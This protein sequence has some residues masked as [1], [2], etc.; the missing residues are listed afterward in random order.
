M[1][2]H[3]G[4]SRKVVLP[5][6]EFDSL[7]DEE[8]ERLDRAN[9]FYF[10][11]IRNFYNSIVPEDQQVPKDAEFLRFF[12][13]MS[14][15]GFF[16][17]DAIYKDILFCF[18]GSVY[19]IEPEHLIGSL[20]EI[21][22]DITKKKNPYGQDRLSEFYYHLFKSMGYKPFKRKVLCIIQEKPTK[23]FLHRD[24]IKID[25]KNHE[26]RKWAGLESLSMVDILKENLDVNELTVKVINKVNNPRAYK[27]YLKLK[28]IMERIDDM[29]VIGT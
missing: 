9:Q 7:T 16:N 17:I 25:M 21:V 10:A 2:K 20:I 4:K 5:Y 6:R 12:R 24:E 15:S 23:D 29:G 3:K 18:L 22:G 11:A 13:V 8:L 1:S 19:D 27:N 28:R 14:A 26:F